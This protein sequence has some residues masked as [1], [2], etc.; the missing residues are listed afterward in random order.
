VRA[1]ERRG[2]V[3]RQ[4][5]RA[6]RRHGSRRDKR[7]HHHVA[8]ALRRQRRYDEAEE[9]YWEAI[10]RNRA[11]GDRRSVA[12]ELQNVGRLAQPRALRVLPVSGFAIPY[13]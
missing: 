10:E 12:L 5:E 9:F 8:E 1:R 13:Q 4:R 7:R 3:G 6:P 2:G 11:M